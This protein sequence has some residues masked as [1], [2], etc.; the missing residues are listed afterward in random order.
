MPSSAIKVICE[1]CTDQKN[2]TFVGDTNPQC[3]KQ[4]SPAIKETYYHVYV[5]FVE[6]MRVENSAAMQTRTSKETK[7]FL[8]M[9]M[10]SLVVDLL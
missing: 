1:K 6:R 5:W 2:M 7:R 10:G 9:V 8:C 4:W 3:S